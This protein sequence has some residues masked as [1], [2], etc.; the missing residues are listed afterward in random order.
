LKGVVDAPNMKMSD[1]TP[2]QFSFQDE[3]KKLTLQLDRER[4]KSKSM[5]RKMMEI[6]EKQPGILHSY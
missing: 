5:A 6:N 4:A 1:S 3:L 2:P